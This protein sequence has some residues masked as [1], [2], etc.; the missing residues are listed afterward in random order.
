VIF[1]AGGPQRDIVS[2]VENDFGFRKS[3]IVLYFSFS[4]SGAVVAQ[5]D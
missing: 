5:Y 3:C 2:P 1:S 4:D